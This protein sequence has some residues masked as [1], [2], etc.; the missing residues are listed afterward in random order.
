MTKQK[1]IYDEDCYLD[2]EDIKS[3]KQGIKDIKEGNVISHEKLKKELG[4]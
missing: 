1:E 3:I 4:L 2:A